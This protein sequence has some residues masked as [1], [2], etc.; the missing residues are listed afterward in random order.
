MYDVTMIIEKNK[1]SLLEL[2]KAT[3]YCTKKL[4]TP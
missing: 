1:M 2:L 3:Y 4:K